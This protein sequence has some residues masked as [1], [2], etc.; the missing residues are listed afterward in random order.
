MQYL[1]IAIDA[2]VTVVK[3]ISIP[4][5]NNMMNKY[6]TSHVPAHFPVLAVPVT[7]VDGLICCRLSVIHVQL[8]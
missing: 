8:L 5:N 1:R 3:V 2:G 6:I 7:A 4:R